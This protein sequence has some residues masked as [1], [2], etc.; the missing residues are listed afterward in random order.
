MLRLNILCHVNLFSRVFFLVKR[1]GTLAFRCGDPNQCLPNLLK[2]L[3]LALF[4]IYT[5]SYFWNNLSEFDSLF[6]QHDHSAAISSSI[7]GQTGFGPGFLH[8]PHHAASSLVFFC[9]R[10][11]L[12]GVRMQKNVFEREHRLRRVSNDPLTV[13]SK[14][15]DIV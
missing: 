5:R 10:L 11:N 6:N 1:G 14:K 8:S 15:V 9:S 7:L 3:L 4:Q 12:Y 2:T 13:F